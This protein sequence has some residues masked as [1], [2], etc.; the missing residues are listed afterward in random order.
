M[1]EVGG[2]LKELEII[3]QGKTNNVRVVEQGTS[4]T[5][6]LYPM[7]GIHPLIPCHNPVLR[8]KMASSPQ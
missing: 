6:Q 2:N 4:P 1:T 3:V 7:S 5:T 8:Q